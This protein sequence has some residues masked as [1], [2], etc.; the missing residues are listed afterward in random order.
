MR[1]SHLCVTSLMTLQATPDDRQS[2]ANTM[3]QLARAKLR[4][5]QQH[6]IVAFLWRA[7]GH[8]LQSACAESLLG[9]ACWQVW[10]RR[11]PRLLFEMGSSD[12][13][14]KYRV[15]SILRWGLSDDKL[16]GNARAQELEPQ[17]AL[18]LGVIQADST[19]A[20]G[21]LLQAGQDVQV[22]STCCVLV[23]KYTRM[24]STACKSQHGRQICSA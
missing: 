5:P 7:R 21:P 17:L 3:Q 2:I 24:P 8:S 23:P 13:E 16:G 14:A 11:M 20:P 12:S 6:S 10:L 19:L 9:R 15:L 1:Q 18:T 4:V 22:L